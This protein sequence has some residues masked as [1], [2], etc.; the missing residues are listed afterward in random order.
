MGTSSGAGAAVELRDIID[1]YAQALAAVDV[2]GLPPGANPRTGEVYLPGLLALAEDRVVKAVDAWWASTHP[3]DLTDPDVERLGIRYPS[4][5]GHRTACDHVLT[6]DGQLEPPEWAIEWKRAALVGN[7]G[8]GNDFTTG[9]FLSPFLKD[10]SLLHDALRLKMYAPARRLAIVGYG[11]AY[12]ASTCDRATARHP[13]HAETIDNVR[14]GCVNNGGELS[15]QPLIDFA[16]SI[17][18]VRGLVTG[19]RQQANFEAWTHPA[20]GEGVVFGWEVRQPEREAGFDPRHP[21]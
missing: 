12:S 20:G 13:D 14:A 4:L 2:A 18:Q 1:R 21:W 7:N 10:R 5:Q 11:F 17:L 19:G 3:E 6:T 8:K 15:L 9:K 16:D